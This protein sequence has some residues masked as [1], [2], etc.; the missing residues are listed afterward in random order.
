LA[1][2]PFERERLNDAVHTVS[3]RDGTFPPARGCER[4]DRRL[5]TGAILGE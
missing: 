5:R 4:R 1:F 3:L 2:W